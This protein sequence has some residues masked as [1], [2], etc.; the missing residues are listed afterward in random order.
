MLGDTHTGRISETRTGAG[1]RTPTEYLTPPPSS[2]SRRGRRPHTEPPSSSPSPSSSPP[3]GA[4][5]SPTER[6]PGSVERRPRVQTRRPPSSKETSP[7]R[8]SVS[9]QTADDGP[10]EESEHS[11]PTGSTLSLLRSPDHTPTAHSYKT[12]SSDMSPVASRQE[13]FRT[14]SF[15]TTNEPE[16]SEKQAV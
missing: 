8:E 13:S 7:A 2:I 5:R 9:Y 12:A 1:S 16:E 14:G 3:T 15:K 4:S 10:E 6:S 11:T